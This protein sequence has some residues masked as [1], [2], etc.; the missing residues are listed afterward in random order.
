MSSSMKL[1]VTSTVL[2]NMGDAAIFNGL[3]KTLQ[4]AYRGRIVATVYDSD[5]EV[6]SQS[7][8][9]AKFRPLLFHSMRNGNILVRALRRLRLPERVISAINV[10]RFWAGA[11]LVRQGRRAAHGFLTADEYADLCTFRDADLVVS[12]GGT[13]LVENYSLE[14]RILDYQVAL[15]FGKPLVFFTQS[16]GPF[17]NERNQERLRPIFNQAE[18]VLLRDERSRSHLLEIGVKPDRLRV[19][20]DGAFMLAESAAWG[21]PSRQHGSPRVAISVREWKHFKGQDADEGM[22]NYLQAIRDLVVHLVTQRETDV[23]F[24]STCQGM[25]EYRYD[26]SAVADRIVEMLPERVRD[27]VRVDHDF[28]NPNEFQRL[29]SSFD[30]MI[31]TRMHAAILSLGAGVPV[32]PIE[33]E[34]KTRELFE[35]LGQSHLV[36]DIEE[37][38]GIDLIA[39]VESILGDL[40]AA[41]DSFKEQVEREQLSA[42]SAADV[43]PGSI[44]SHDSVLV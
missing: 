41:H 20:A 15:F 9:D 14:P 33:Y 24:L 43:F 42:C 11:S 8:P 2:L 6:A 21:R 44:S 36:H 27:Q 23:V 13:Y 40:G 22:Q 39:S 18:L 10:K 30:L 35:R 26:D 25:P 4:R 37:V 16:L 31:A 34:F 17:R 19:V 12:T 3:I 28:H 5:P 7:Y 32:L 29:V 38:R 1:V